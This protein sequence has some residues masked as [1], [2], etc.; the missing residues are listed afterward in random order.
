MQIELLNAG[1]ISVIFGVL[2]FFFPLIVGKLFCKIQGGLG[3]DGKAAYLIVSGC[4]YAGIL[5][6]LGS[7]T[8]GC[9]DSKSASVLGKQVLI[10]S[11]G[12]AINTNG[13]K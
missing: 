3:G 10:I 8:P 13:D 11:S 9:N 2:A 6:C 12:D 1:F 7:N 4:I 5:L